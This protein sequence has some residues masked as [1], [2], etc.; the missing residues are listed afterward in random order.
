VS[1]VAAKAVRVEIVVAAGLSEHFS[2]LWL[3]QNS[4][5]GTSSILQ[6]SHRGHYEHIYMVLS[7]LKHPTLKPYRQMTQ[8]PW[9]ILLSVSISLALCEDKIEKSSETNTR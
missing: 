2:F 9:G 3:G 8:F 1:D 7:Q 5:R 6:T 4:G